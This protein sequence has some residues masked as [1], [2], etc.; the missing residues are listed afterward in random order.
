MEKDN[1][2]IQP[3][4]YLQLGPILLTINKGPTIPSA[5]DT[6]RTDPFGR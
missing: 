1:I 5:A 6:F 2:I 3:F 4:L